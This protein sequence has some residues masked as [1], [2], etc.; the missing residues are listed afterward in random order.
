MP[1][2]NGSHSKTPIGPFQKTVFAA[3]IRRA[4]SARESGTDVE[5]EPAVRER[6]E[7]RHLRLRVGL[8]RA[9]RDD[10]G[11]QHD[12]ERERVLVAQLLGHLA[13]DE[14]L[15]RAAAEVLQ[16]AQL[17]L[18]LRAAG[19]E[20]ERPLDLAEQ[21]SEVLELREQQETGVG[22]QQLR[23]ARRSRRARGGPS[24]TRR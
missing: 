1:S 17:V 24:R 10:V 21:A 6:V 20:H 19:D 8:E 3:R 15:V 18:H 16:H 23:D 5:P 11:R 14:H 4:K 7:R 13:A 22:G 2:A 12:R 9:R